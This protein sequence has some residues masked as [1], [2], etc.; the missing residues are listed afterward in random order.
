MTTPPPIAPPPPPVAAPLAPTTIALGATAELV[1][2]GRALRAAGLRAP[3]RGD[4]AVVAGA[5]AF[6][7][8]ADLGD[9]MAGG[10]QLGLTV[11]VGAE[12]GMR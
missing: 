4:L 7:G 10:R 2:F 11:T 8:V 1:G 6:L 9:A 5:N 3:V 12:I